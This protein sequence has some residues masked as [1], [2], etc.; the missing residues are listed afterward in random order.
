[1]ANKIVY[2]KSAKVTFDIFPGR[3]LNLEQG[4]KTE[5]HIIH[6]AVK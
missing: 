6:L 4:V 2:E 5:N 3:N 1:M